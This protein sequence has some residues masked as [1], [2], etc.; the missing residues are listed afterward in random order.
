[1]AHVAA[2]RTTSLDYHAERDKMIA[3]RLRRGCHVEQGKRGAL[4][5]RHG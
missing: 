1:M 2:L 4:D 3:L 5:S